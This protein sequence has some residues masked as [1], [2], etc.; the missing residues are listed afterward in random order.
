[1]KFLIFLIFLV[2]CQAVKF[3]FFGTSTSDFQSITLDNLESFSLLST[4]YFDP[5]KPNAVY[6]HGWNDNPTNEGPQ[7]MM[8]AYLQ[9][10]SEF[11][12]ILLDWGEIACSSIFFDIPW[13]I[14]TVT[15]QAI[16]ILDTIKN[17]GF[18]ITNTHLIGYS[19][20]SIIAGNIG[21]FFK[22]NRAMRIPR[23]TGLDPPFGF[24][25]F[26]PLY[27]IRFLVRLGRGDASFVDIIHT[28][29]LQIG[30]AIAR[31]HVDFWPNEGKCQ[32]GCSLVTLTAYQSSSK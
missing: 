25:S 13:D 2:E 20:G 31:G 19:F 30:D 6:I 18:D 12:A 10:K 23:I 5:S 9:R 32:P 26:E 17:N 15:G 7:T 14:S 22:N 3:T 11:N 1:M 21:R 24:G 29:A 27:L 16:D 8:A 28:N 4:D